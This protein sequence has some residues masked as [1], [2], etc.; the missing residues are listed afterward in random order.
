LTVLREALLAGRLAAFR[1]QSE[2][3][4]PLRWRRV[5]PYGLLLG[6][7]YYLVA[8]VGATAAPILFRLD[9]IS[10][11]MSFTSPRR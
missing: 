9:R 4:G 10:N 1:Y 7:R 6:S 2:P 3:K 8:R 11:V 5:I